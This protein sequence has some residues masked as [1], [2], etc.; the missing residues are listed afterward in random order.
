MAKECSTIGTAITSV[1]A[2]Y[3]KCTDFG[4]Y[5]GVGIFPVKTENHIQ[6]TSQC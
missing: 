4:V 3:V 2:L 6:S 1:S 5:V